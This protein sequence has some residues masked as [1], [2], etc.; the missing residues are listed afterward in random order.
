MP[1][2]APKPQFLP[3]IGDYV[4]L[5]AIGSTFYGVFSANNTP[6][7]TNFQNGVTYQRNADFATKTLLG[8]DNVT[9]VAVSIDP[10]F[11][12]VHEVALDPCIKWPWLCVPGLLELGQIVLD[13]PVRNCIVIDPIPKNCLVKFDCPGC[14]PGALCPPWYHVFLDGLGDVWNTGLF[15]T[16]GKVVPHQQFKT[17]TGIVLSFRPSAED[18]IEGQ[19]GSYFLAFEMGPKG[20]L[21]V[22]YR[23]RTRV[24]RSDRPYQ[25][26]KPRQ[27]N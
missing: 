14:P 27:A 3:Y 10:F 25:P 26:A 2:N 7:P 16:R 11:F 18:Y 8:T 20:K 5:M 24:E 9:P 6:D 4:H 15:D 12:R 13:C 21:G 23:V 17:P 19:I 1:A 22:K